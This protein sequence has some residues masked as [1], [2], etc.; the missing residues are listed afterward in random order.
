MGTFRDPRYGLRLQ[1]IQAGFRHDLIG[2]RLSI[3]VI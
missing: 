1:L 2:C 3:T